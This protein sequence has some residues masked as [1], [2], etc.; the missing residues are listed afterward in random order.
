MALADLAEAD[1]VMRER[2][3]GTRQVAEQLLAERGVDPDE[4]RV[5]VELGTGEAIVS[6]VEGGLGVAM[7]SR[8]VAEKALALGT[9]AR[10]DLAGRPS[11][12]RSTRC[13]P[14]A[15]RRVPP[16]AFAEYLAA[17]A[18]GLTRRARRVR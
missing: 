2:G 14:R 17:V 4:L 10:V 9:V 1:W 3:S 11:C 18:A 6:A 7:L 13:C 12:G 15:R 16:S 8:Q 5:V